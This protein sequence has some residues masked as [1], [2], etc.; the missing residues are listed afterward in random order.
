MI[1]ELNPV[2]PWDIFQA[3]YNEPYPFIL[4]STVDHENLGRF[5]FVGFDPFLVIRARGPNVEVIEGHKRRETPGDPLSILSSILIDLK[6]PTL[7]HTPFQGGA[8]GYIGYD[9][10]D[11]I[12]FDRKPGLSLRDPS[13]MS[14][15]ALARNLVVPLGAGSGEA[16]LSS[17]VNPT[18][19][20][21]KDIPD[22]LLGLYDTIFIHD[23]L[24][25]R[26]YILSTGLPEGDEVKR[27]ILAKERLKRCKR[28]LE[29]L[30]ISA[31]P[32]GYERDV[33]SLV[34]NF[35]RE[36]YINTIKRAKDYISAGDI[37]QINLS[38]RFTIPYPGDP[39]QLYSRLRRVNPTPF[40]AFLNLGDFQVISNS[41]ES[42]LRIRDGIIE[43][44]PIKG[45]RPRGGNPVEDK[46]LVKELIESPKE[47]AEHIMIV[48]LERNDLG[49]VC[50]YGTIEVVE[51]EKVVSL[52]TL[53]HMVSTVRG[54]IRDGLGPIECIRACFP[55]GSVTGAP[56]VRAMEI[57][58]ELEPDPRGVYT[59]AIGYIDFSG[60]MDLAM[61]IRTAVLI[62]DKLYL[63]V[64]GGIVADSIPEGEYEETLLK[65]EAFF[66]A[67][68][69]GG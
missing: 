47:R 48:D 18:H 32:E 36:A 44:R 20:S 69:Q 64:G 19:H 7:P 49:R 41:P 40:G 27:E 33:R 14:F 54:E 10:R 60:N 28:S 45:T 12:A 22:L 35:T 1:E 42:F 25:L 46:A 30:P 39:I 16:I 9:S 4:D 37:Y 58:D 52:P 51:L 21:E 24:T 56:K 17:R 38:Q 43:T 53:H 6:Q 29:R 13:P 23:H 55:G 2:D 50:H 66:R 62:R 26:S 68:G 31:P 3:I 8:V 63:S 15:R 57:I 65:G 34:A 5:S 61:V 67:M 59:G 11:F